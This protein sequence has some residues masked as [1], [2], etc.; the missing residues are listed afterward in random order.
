MGITNEKIKMRKLWLGMQLSYFQ[1]FYYSENKKILFLLVDIVP[2]I[3][4]TI[5][6]SEV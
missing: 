2:N 1:A 6:E 4:Y 3:R 5:L